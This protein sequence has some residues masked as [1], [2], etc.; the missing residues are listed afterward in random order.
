MPIKLSILQCLIPSLKYPTAM[1]WDERT[2]CRHVAIPRISITTITSTDRHHR[3]PGLHANQKQIPDIQNDK[4]SGQFHF[5]CPVVLY[6][7]CDNSYSLTIKI[8]YSSQ[9][10]S[11]QTSSPEMR[12]AWFKVK[13]VTTFWVNEWHVS[14]VKCWMTRISGHFSQFFFKYQEFNESMEVPKIKKKKHAITYAQLYTGN[15]FL[16]TI[17]KQK[18]ANT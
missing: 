12:L 15:A 13:L 17:R 8:F 16:F 2:A 3:T 11:S 18:Q 6:C 4:Q 7:R 14:I 1:L 10:L 9:H 5:K